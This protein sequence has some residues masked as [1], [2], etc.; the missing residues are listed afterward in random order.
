MRKLIGISALALGAAITVS[1]AAAQLLNLGGG[2]EPLIEL[3]SGNEPGLT[4]NLGTESS[5]NVE[6]GGN[7]EVNVNLNESTGS[8][9]SVELPL[10]EGDGDSDGLGEIIDLD[11]SD[12][13]IGVD[14][15]SK[16]N[17]NEVTVGLPTGDD[18]IVDLFGNGVGGLPPPDSD[19]LD[20]GLTDGDAIL[21]I[22]G[23]GVTGGNTVLENTVDLDVLNN[24]GGILPADAVD[25]G[26]VDL[27]D[28]EGVLGGDSIVDLFG[29]GGGVE[30]LNLG[31]VTLPDV[32]LSHLSILSSLAEGDTV[33]VDD[34]TDLLPDDPDTDTDTDTDVTTIDNR[35]TV[36]VTGGTSTTGGSTITATNRTNRVGTTNRATRLPVV[37]KPAA[38]AQAPGKCF[39]PNDEQ[40]NHLVSSKSYSG[41]SV[42]TWRTAGA[43]TLVPVRLCPEART[44][45][46]EVTY[47][48]A[49]MAA[50][51]AGI[52]A[53][54]AIQGKLQGTGLDSEDV[55]AVGAK[56]GQV[57]VYVY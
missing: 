35:R 28:L 11:A 33:D 1:P 16:G 19:Q 37:K 31:D 15:D 7:P 44:R 45:V 49:N 46:S 21:D 34:D 57:V 6:L 40:I 43:V 30:A 14:L 23:D 32:D 12:D 39:T 22:F 27:L 38:V 5:V 29:E 4:V 10:G 24:V 20:L 13:I 2:G 53:S 48:N 41:D 51:R 18:L 47:G 42:A 54:P 25:V 52:A 50:M 55:L 56:D 9:L 8:G 3:G 17:D 26:D 36:I